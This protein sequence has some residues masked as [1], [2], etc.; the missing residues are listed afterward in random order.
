MRVPHAAP[1]LL[2]LV[3]RKYVIPAFPVFYVYAR[4]SRRHAEFIETA[5]DIETLVLPA[6][7]PRPE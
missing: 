2:P 1:L 4:G 3:H 5:G 7:P 6:L